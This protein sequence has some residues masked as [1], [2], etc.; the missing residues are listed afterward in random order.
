MIKKISPQESG[1]L[2]DIFHDEIVN[3]ERLLNWDFA[4]W[5]KHG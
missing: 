3:L 2:L 4:N 1:Y 5:K